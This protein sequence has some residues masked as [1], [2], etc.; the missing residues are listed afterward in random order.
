M[1]K[2]NSSTKKQVVIK[3]L[4]INTIV[5]LQ[6]NKKEQNWSFKTEHTGSE[7]YK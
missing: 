3:K 2:W 7:T 4:P 5:I 6:T 1:P